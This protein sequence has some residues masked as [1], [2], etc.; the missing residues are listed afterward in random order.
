MLFGAAT[1][2]LGLVAIGLTID[3]ARLYDAQRQLQSATNMAAMDAARVA[4]GCFGRAALGSDPAAAARNE[5]LAAL[6][7]NG[8][9]REWLAGGGSLRLGRIAREGSLRRFSPMEAPLPG[10]VGPYNAVELRLTRDQPSR[11]IPGMGADGT[12]GALTAV[13]AATSRPAARF[14]VG[15]GLAS[16]SLPDS[17]LNELISGALGGPSPQISLLSYRNLFDATVSIGRLD[18]ELSPGSVASSLDQL[19]SSQGLL[20]ALADALGAAGEAAAAETAAA[21]AAVAANAPPVVPAELIGLQDGLEEVAG[22]ILINAGVLVNQ[23]LRESARGTVESIPITIPCPLGPC[24]GRLTLLDPGG[25]ETATP[26]LIETS[27]TEQIASTAQVALE[28]LGLQVPILNL[29]NIAVDVMVEAAPA[30]AQVIDIE[31]PRSGAT[32]GAVTL[33]GRTG[34][35]TATI[36]VSGNLSGLLSIQAQPSPLVLGQSLNN[37]VPLRFVGPFDAETGDP[38]QTLGTPTYASLAD[39]LTSAV[40]SP[41]D[42]RISVA[43]LQIPTGGLLGLGNTLTNA[44][45]EN[46]IRSELAGVLGQVGNQLEPLLEALGVQ[47]GYA[48]FRV[49]SV[50]DAQP[51]L[52]LR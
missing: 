43:G 1:A 52:F 39:A 13:A 51:A 42:L 11:L 32:E 8:V 2:L 40:L 50:T 49:Y 20:I 25:D 9:S 23:V 10:A 4:G 38:A 35:A 6:D 17:V 37:P 14:G 18:L 22:S 3:L 31:C 41:T 27:E 33:L 19:V 36:R 44:A 34:L 26:V 47:L 16:V 29:G 30:T 46:L 7:R 21:L 48:D 12:R 15:S 28:I 45:V 24:E 5:A